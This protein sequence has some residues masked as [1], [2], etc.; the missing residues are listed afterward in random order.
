MGALVP[1]DDARELEQLPAERAA[2]ER[3]GIEGRLEILDEQP[4][5]QDG[6]VLLGRRGG[7]RRQRPCRQRS[8]AAGERQAATDE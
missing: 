4:E 5:A 7:A 6:G 2:V 1:G 8:A 3:I